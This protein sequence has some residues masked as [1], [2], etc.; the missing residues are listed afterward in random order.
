MSNEL[1]EINLPNVGPV[2]VQQWTIKNINADGTKNCDRCG[3]MLP[4]ASPRDRR[5][6]ILWNHQGIRCQATET[7]LSG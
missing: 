5:I 4:I 2:R 3:N 1:V 6:G 7:E